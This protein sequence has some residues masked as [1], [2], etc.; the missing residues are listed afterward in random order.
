MRWK[1]L[2]FCSQQTL[3]SITKIFITRMRS[4]GVFRRFGFSDTPVLIG[5]LLF[6]SVFL[7]VVYDVDGLEQSEYSFE[8]HCQ[9]DLPKVR[10]PG[11]CV[12]RGTGIRS[13]LEDRSDEAER[14]ECLVSLLPLAGGYGSEQSPVLRGALRSD[15]RL[16]EE[17]S[18]MVVSFLFCLL[19]DEQHSICRKSA[20]FSHRSRLILFWRR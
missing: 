10:V 5:L 4:G 17:D 16:G 18:V 6:I 15:F 1:C 7:C 13:G 9:C 12:C 2:S 20:V 8:W 14:G 11:R 19:D 3:P